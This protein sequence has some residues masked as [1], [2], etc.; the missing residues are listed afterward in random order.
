MTNWNDEAQRLEAG[1]ANLNSKSEVQNYCG[2][3]T[4]PIDQIVLEEKDARLRDA[5]REDD[6]YNML[7][8][9]IGEN[10]LRQPVLVRRRK[11]DGKFVILDGVQRFSCVSDLGLTFINANYYPGITDQ[12]VG[13]ILMWQVS[14]NI[15]RIETKKGDLA[16]QFLRVLTLNPGMT[17][18][19]LADQAKVTQGYV[20]QIMSLNTLSDEILKM[21]NDGDIGLA[22]AVQLSKLPEDEQELFVDR[23]KKLDTNEFAMAVKQRKMVL[24]NERRGMPKIAWQPTFMARNTADL[25]SM[26]AGLQQELPGDFNFDNIDRE[27]PNFIAGRYYQALWCG[28]LDPDSVKR[29]VEDHSKEEADRERKKA[30]RK[31]QRDAEKAAK[32]GTVATGLPVVKVSH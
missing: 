32:E 13:I 2:L 5:Q 23:A 1:L 16:R 14:T 10:G 30:E 3:L 7:K 31:A 19:E 24:Q 21:V 26:I 4:L 15:H 6:K 25:R 12:D 22:N 11:S 17:Q 28:H 20:S 9:D 29:Q 27:D 18:A 8:A